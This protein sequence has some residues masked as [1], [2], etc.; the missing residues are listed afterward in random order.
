M[1]DEKQYPYTTV[2][3]RLKE[4]LDK[5]SGLGRPE[6]AGGAWLKELGYTSGNDKTVLS[7]IRRVGMVTPGG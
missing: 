1:A 2:P 7:A 6:K 4:L 3:G 5:L